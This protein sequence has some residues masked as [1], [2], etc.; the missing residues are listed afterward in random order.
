MTVKKVTINY[1]VTVK[2]FNVKKVKKTKWKSLECHMTGPHAF[3]HEVS[4]FIYILILISLKPP[5]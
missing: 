5:T 4:A 3:S 1:W 2:K